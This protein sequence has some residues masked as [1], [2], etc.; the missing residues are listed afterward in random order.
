MNL[1]GYAGGDPVNNSDPFGLCP[2][3]LRD[4]RGNCPGG[5]TVKEWQSVEAELQNMTN[6]AAA[7]TSGLLFGGRIHGANLAPDVAGR[8]SSRTPG[9][10]DINRTA[11]KHGSIFE[12]SLIGPTLV[13]EGKHVDQLKG[14]AAGREAYDYAKAHEKKLEEEAKAYERA[15]YKKP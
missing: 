15:N 1:Y 2:E 13:H 14:K 4:A 8:V 12:S 6:E 5:I 11:G 9:D 3:K 7:R 10:I